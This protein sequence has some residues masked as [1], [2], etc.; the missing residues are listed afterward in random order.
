[1]IR[2][3]QH[4]VNKLSDLKNISQLNDFVERGVEFD[5]RYHLGKE[6]LEHDI[7]SKLN[8]FFPFDELKDNCQNLHSIINFKE[9][10]GELKTFKKLSKLFKST[11]LLDIPF[12]EYVKL[13]NNGLSKFILWRLSEYEKPSISQIKKFQGEWIWLDSFHNYWFD[14]SELK[15]YKDKGLKIILVSNELQGRNIKDNNDLIKKLI[16]KKLIDAICTKSVDF[17]LKMF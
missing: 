13:K 17:Y 4:R 5:L 16:N 14:D 15:K 12:P 3:Y 9:T 7:N 1:M 10:G 2:F 8:N 11:L 6:Y